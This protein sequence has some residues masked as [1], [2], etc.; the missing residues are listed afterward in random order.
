M[1]ASLVFGGAIFWLAARR[2]RRDRSRRC[3][4]ARCSTEPRMVFVLIGISAHPVWIGLIFATSSATSWAGRRSPATATSSTRPGADCGGPVQWA[5]HM[6]L[7]WATFA[8]L[9]AALYVRMIR[10]NVMETMNEDYVR[11][12]RAKGAPEQPR[13][14]LARPAQRHAAGRH[15]A[16]DGHR[17]RARRRHLHGDRLQPARPRASSRS[18]RYKNFDLPVIMGVVV[19]A[20]ICDHHLQPD[21]RPPL[22]LYRPADQAASLMALLEVQRPADDFRTDDGVVKAVDGVTFSSRRAR[23]SGSSASPAAARAS[24]A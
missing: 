9:F 11:T 13:H 23:R 5:Y 16:R 14:A 20:T 6:I 21:R 12:A 15:H 8:L 4:R 19:F 3:G 10:A 24:P 1:T 7:P 18:R 22:R 17:P 2:S